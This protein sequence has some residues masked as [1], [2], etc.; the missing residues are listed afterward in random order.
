MYNSSRDAR[1]RRLTAS[2]HCVPFESEHRGGKDN[3]AAPK[4]PSPSRSAALRQDP[5]GEAHREIAAGFAPEPLG[6]SGRTLDGDL[7]A[8]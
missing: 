2:K 8:L 3:A 6:V 4:R 1:K 5:L 7:E